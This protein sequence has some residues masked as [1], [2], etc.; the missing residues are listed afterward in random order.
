MSE[1][2]KAKKIKE[3]KDLPGVGPSTVEKLREAGFYDLMSIAASALSK[4]VE[5]AGLSE[6]VSRKIINIARESLDMGFKI[7]TKVEKD[8]EKIVRISTGSPNFDLLVGGGIET[9]TITECYGEFG[10]GKT[11]IGHLLSVNMLKQDP[12][13]IVVYI[14][15]E[16]TFK[17]GRIRQFAKGAGLN[18][19]DTLKRILVAKALSSDHQM[20]LAENVEKLISKEG[21]NIKLIV[22]DSLT[23]HL[24]VEYLGRGTLADRQQTLNRHMHVL[25]KLAD[26][27][28]ICV[29]VTNQVMSNPAQM[30]GDPT[31]PIGGHI[32]G[33]NSA[34][35][36][37]LR[38]G[39]KGSRVA[40]LV[41]SPDLP[42]GEVAFEVTEGGLKDI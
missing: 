25:S 16:N 42:D 17:P 40:K 31:V 28:N 20:L 4:I 9:G 29:Y 22:V 36:I 35:R 8:K 1:D 39:K 10:S 38:K 30:F 21:K 18:E 41:D 24:R 32:V 15:T 14:D 19:E 7:G 23:A 33:H 27:H 2:K 34:T 3:I 13:A 37:Y 5:V 6:A 12:K 11:Q 26:S